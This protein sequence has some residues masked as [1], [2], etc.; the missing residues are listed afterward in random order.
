MIFFTTISLVCN[1]S[2][3]SPTRFILQDF[4]IA[5]E[6]K[7]VTDLIKILKIHFIAQKFFEFFRPIRAFIVFVGKDTKIDFWTTLW[8]DFRISLL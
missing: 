4:D 8:A 2:Y 6:V 7:L 5:E 1:I 3:Y